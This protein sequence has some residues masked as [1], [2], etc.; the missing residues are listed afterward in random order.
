MMSNSRK[1]INIRNKIQTGSYKNGKINAN[2]NTTM[3]ANSAKKKRLLMYSF[4]KKFKVEK[5]KV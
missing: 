5:F 2:V 3:M 1:V 4:L